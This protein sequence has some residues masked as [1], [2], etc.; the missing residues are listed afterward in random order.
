[1]K[2]DLS[3]RRAVISG[4]TAGI[5]FAIARG[6]AAAGAAVVINGRSKGSVDAAVSR[7]LREVPAAAVTGID[8]DL[9][10][11]AGVELFLT[12]SGEQT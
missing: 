8:A 7:L 9:A 4:S 11:A 12:H 3:G 1:M 5:G 10:T 6:L 2:I